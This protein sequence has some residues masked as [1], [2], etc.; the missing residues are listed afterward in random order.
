MNSGVPTTRPV[1]VT[2][3]PPPSPPTALAKPK[4]TTFTASAPSRPR[5]SMM[6]S[7]FKSRCTMPRSCAAWSAAATWMQMSAAR[8]G[9]RALARQQVRE[10]LAL[11]E[12]HREI[13]EPVRSLT[14]IIDGTDVGVRDAAGVRGLA[15]EAGHRLRIVHHGGVH[16]L[17]GAAAPHLHM[18]GEVD[19]P[20]A[21][22]AQLLHDVVAVGKHLAHE[23]LCRAR[24]AQGLPVVR[25]ES[26]LVAILGG[27]DGADLHAGISMRSSL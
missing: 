12:L 15:V 27:T 24:R 1:L 2:F 10:R 3:W 21:S 13:D 9:Q 11:D 4:S 25:A 17:D 22:L 23:I 26:H 14:E 20:H 5:V 19:L 8:D 16:H 6:L 7:G 18:L